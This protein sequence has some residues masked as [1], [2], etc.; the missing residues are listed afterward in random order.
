M[1]RLFGFRSVIP[2]QVHRSL[3]EADNALMR[4]SQK[5]TDGWG[6]AYYLAHTPH[7]IK[8]ANGALDDHL[9]KHVS[10]IVSSET[11]VAHIRQATQGDHSLINSHPFQYGSWIFAHN[12]NIPD[13]ESHRE[14]IT[15]LIPPVLRRFILG[16]TDSEV[17]F[18][19]LLG[20]MARRFDI[21][22]KGYPIEE[23]RNA[24]RE[25]TQQIDDITGLSWGDEHKYYLTFMITNGHLMLA[26]HGGKPL[27]FSTHKTRC[28]ER[29]TCPSF[30][31]ACEHFVTD[32][33]VNHLILSSEE[34][35]GENAWTALERGD[36]IGVDWRMFLH[37]YPKSGET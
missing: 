15:N 5:H 17:I 26:H 12:G 27:L 8:S 3:V 21:N 9:F 16:T 20:N 33:F 14:A 23:L 24:I 31:N 10:G 7:L 11:V 1:C 34:L 29:D 25:T 2:S 19:L 13:F 6:V 30:S 18:Y 32:G 35:Q 22:R 37:R 28:P 4:Q 36:I